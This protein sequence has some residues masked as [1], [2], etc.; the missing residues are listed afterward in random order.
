MILAEKI[1]SALIFIRTLDGLSQHPGMQISPADVE[2]AIAS[3][4]HFLK[5]IPGFTRKTSVSANA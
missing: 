5:E 3:G 1:P 4:L 2:L